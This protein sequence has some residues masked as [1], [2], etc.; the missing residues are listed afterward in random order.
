MS[1]YVKAVEFSLINYQGHYLILLR[2]KPHR[3]TCG[4]D[5]FPSTI[6]C[7]S[8][9]S[10]CILTRLTFFLLA[11]FFYA[12]LALETLYLYHAAA[13]L[14]QRSYSFHPGRPQN[15]LRS[16]ERPVVHGNQATRRQ[17]TACTDDGMR[18][19]LGREGNTQ[20]DHWTGD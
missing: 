19:R 8:P 9:R 17:R 18:L 13:H 12:R 7:S 3:K 5:D 14:Y 6:D 16:A 2:V 15:L 1:L 20:R 4:F 11:S 10:G